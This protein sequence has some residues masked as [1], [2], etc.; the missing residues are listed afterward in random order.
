LKFKPGMFCRTSLE[1]PAAKGVFV[2]INAIYRQPGTGDEFLFVVNDDNTVSRIPVK[3]GET[4][5][6]KIHIPE[7]AAGIRV[8]IDGKNK[9][10]EGTLVEI[11]KE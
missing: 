3:R 8:V 4:V 6:D 10:D 2:P 9:L 1:L 5:K 7:I 11:V